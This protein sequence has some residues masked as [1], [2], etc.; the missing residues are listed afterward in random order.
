LSGKLSDKE[1]DW[2]ASAEGRM[3]I[4]GVF[5]AEKKLVA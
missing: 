5:G 2:I 4:A 1:F 3:C